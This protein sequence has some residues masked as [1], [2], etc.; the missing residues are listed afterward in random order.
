MPHHLVAQEHERL[1]AVE[2]QILIDNLTCFNEML[3]KRYGLTVHSDYFVQEA[4][5]TSI[6]APYMSLINSF[7]A[8]LLHLAYATVHKELFTFKV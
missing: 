3:T 2:K 8:R 5:Q 7:M 1:N 6:L 4:Y